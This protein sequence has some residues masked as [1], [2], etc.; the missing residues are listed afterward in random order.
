MFNIWVDYPSYDEELAVV[1]RPP[2]TWTSRC[3]R[4]FQPAEEI[5][6]FQ[7]SC[8]IPYP[9][10]CW[11]TRSGWRP[12]HAQVRQVH[13]TTVQQHVSWEPVPGPPNTWSSAPNV[14]PWP[15][16]DSLR[17]SRTQAVARRSCVT[18]W[19]APQGRGPREVRRLLVEAL[20]DGLLPVRTSSANFGGIEEPR[21]L[22]PHATSCSPAFAVLTALLVPGPGPANEHGH[23]WWTTGTTNS[24][25]A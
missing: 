10:T 3:L 9:R 22:H 15:E 19:C 6:R 13:R 12:A 21:E 24:R 16:V 8:R 23:R 18:G 25:S 5:L 11:S 20:L 14:T 7:G 1:K 4:S 2:V 17:T